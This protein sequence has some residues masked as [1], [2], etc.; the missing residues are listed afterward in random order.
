MMEQTK[1]VL[2]CFAGPCGE[3]AAGAEVGRRNVTLTPA[4]PA[5]RYR[6]FA[7]RRGCR[8]TPRRA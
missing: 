4:E 1:I 8:C 5:R 7:S 6:T 3:R 2:M